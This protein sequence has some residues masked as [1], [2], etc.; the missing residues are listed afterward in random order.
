MIWFLGFGNIW[1]NNQ[2]ILEIGNIL[3]CARSTLGEIAR[4]FSFLS[5]IS[6]VSFVDRSKDG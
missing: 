1:E 6:G 3:C 4:G 5:T 2:F